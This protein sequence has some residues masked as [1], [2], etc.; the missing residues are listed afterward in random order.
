MHSEG[1]EARM[2]PSTAVHREVLAHLLEKSTLS[3]MALHRA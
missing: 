1:M 3:R 2:H